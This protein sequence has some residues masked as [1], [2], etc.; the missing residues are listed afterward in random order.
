MPKPQIILMP[1]D[2]GWVRAFEEARADIM[3]ACGGRVIDVVHIGSTAIPGI[4]AKPVIDMLALLRRHRDGFA[5][6]PA[7]AASGFEL[8]GEAGLPGRHF[9]R[10]GDPRTHHVHM[11]QIEAPGSPA[12]HAV[13]RLP[14]PAPRSG[15][16]P[17]RR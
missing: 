13:S 6:V 1:H 12:S 2:P 15:I 17:T 16:C 11:Y 7:M 10:K 4:A 14:A 5:C 8:R 3:E 9:F